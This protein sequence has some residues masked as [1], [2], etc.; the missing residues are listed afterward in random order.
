MV[1]QAAT[2]LPHPA[3]RLGWLKNPQGPDPKSKATGRS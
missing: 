3:N 2:S 1:V